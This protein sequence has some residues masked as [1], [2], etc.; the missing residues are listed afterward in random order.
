MSYLH[1]DDYAVYAL[2]LSTHTHA[3][4]D[5]HTHTH[6][7]HSVSKDRPHSPTVAA[8]WCCHCVCTV[9]LCVMCDCIYKDLQVRQ[10]DHITEDTL[11]QLR[12]VVA[13]ERAGRQIHLRVRKGYK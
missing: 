7:P 11:L 13:M 3:H 12:D 1:E 5:T 6:R 4:M 8:S 9:S 2:S 10:G